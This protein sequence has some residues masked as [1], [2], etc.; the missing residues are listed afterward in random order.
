MTLIM[1]TPIMFTSNKHTDKPTK[2]Q[3]VSNLVEKYPDRAPVYLDRDQYS[4]NTPDIPKKKYLVP[5]TLTVGQFLYFV[6]KCCKLQPEQSL[7]LFVN[8]VIPMC[9]LS[10]SELYE[11]YKSDDGLLRI[12]YSCEN[13]FG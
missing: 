5:R 10:I 1:F 11:S 7:Y 13:T 9:S 12:T 4:T 3:D 2:Q 8:G 6:R